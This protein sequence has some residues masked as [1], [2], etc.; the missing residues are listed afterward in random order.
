MTEQPPTAK[1]GPGDRV[2]RYRPHTH[3]ARTKR[4]QLRYTK[5]EYTAVAQAAHN[6][7][8]TTTGYAADAALATALTLEPPTA[9]P[10]RTVLIELIEARSQ[11]RRVGTNINQ[12]ARALNAT[13]DP[14]PWL[15]HALNIANRTVARLDDAA[16]AIAAQAREDHTK[17]RNFNRQDAASKSRQPL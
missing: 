2:G 16:T 12:A 14:P 10:W 4:L 17:K 9:E 11:V 15:Q 3:P 13:G 7:G 1:P 6:A 5:A 8:L